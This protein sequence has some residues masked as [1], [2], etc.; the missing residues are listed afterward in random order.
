MTYI[1]GLNHFDINSIISDARVTSDDGTGQNISLKTG[2]LF[3]GCIFGRAGNM[4]TSR[5]F[6]LA[7]KS[8]LTGRNTLPGFWQQF[9]DFVSFYD[10]PTGQTDRAGRFQL[11]LSSRCLGKPKF[12][13]L[14][15]YH[16]TVSSVENSWISI[17][18]GREDLDPLVERDY[19]L[20]LDEI[21][22]IIQSYGLPRQ[23]YSYFVCL[24]L[25]E[26][27]LSFE[28]RFL[29]EKGVGGVFHFAFQTSNQEAIQEPALYVFSAANLKTK[30]VTCWLYRVCFV[31]GCLIVEHIIP[32]NQ[33]AAAPLGKHERH[34]F[35]DE[36]SRPDIVTQL[37]SPGFAD[38]MKEEINA[39]PFYQFCGFG[40]LNP[41]HR[42]G[43]G[44]HFTNEGKYVVTKDGEIADEYKAFIVS[45]FE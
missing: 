33:D 40:F 30:Q 9:Q 36:A 7:V 5:D 12:Y 13:L 14:D 2:F 43:F 3:P 20:R 10:M 42:K 19:K 32:P 26:L 25:S 28:K 8:A 27:T 6:I 21:V 31:Q 35:C 16:R 37:E 29:E 39:L 4:A 18:S 11:L 24:W 23:I 38:K 15:S 1:I 41:I 44:Y 17:G 34:A 22:R 45:H